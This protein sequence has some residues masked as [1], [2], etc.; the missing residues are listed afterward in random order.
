MFEAQHGA[1]ASNILSGGASLLAGEPELMHLMRT[2]MGESR[3]GDSGD[4]S[5]STL[6]QEQARRKEE[7]GE[8]I[9][10]KDLIREDASYHKEL[11]AERR[12]KAKR[13]PLI[14]G[15]PLTDMLEE[16]LKEQQESIEQDQRREQ[17]GT[18][19]GRL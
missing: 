15:V 18:R 17:R 12:R 14:H 6:L 11:E 19:S 1:G 16:V 13:D 5:W 10:V 9:S 7:D 4:L 8:L 2:A 3:A